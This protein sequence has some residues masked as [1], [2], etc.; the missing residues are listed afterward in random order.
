MSRLRQLL[1]LFA[2]PAQSQVALLPLPVDRG[3]AEYYASPKNNSLRILTSGFLIEHQQRDT[4]SA[5]EFLLRTGLAPGLA[6]SALGELSALLDLMQRSIYA[7]DLYWTQR[8]LKEKNE[9]ALVRRLAGLVIAELHWEQ[10]ATP[11]QA[12]LL[13]Q[14]YRRELRRA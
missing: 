4:E 9:W 13:V 14:H 11:S 6:P 8:A 1:S 10:A 12:T 3:T 5:E 2:A 7:E